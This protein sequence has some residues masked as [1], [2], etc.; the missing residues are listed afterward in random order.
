MPGAEKIQKLMMRFGYKPNLAVYTRMDAVAATMTDEFPQWER[1]ALSLDLRNPEL[2]QRFQILFN[3][4]YFS[5]DEPSN[6]TESVAMANRLMDF[7]LKKFEIGK[8]ERV[9][10]AYFSIVEDK[11]SFRDLVL[12][13]D[14][15]FHVPLATIPAFDDCHLADT[16]Y[17]VSAK[18]RDTKWSRTVQVGPMIK[19][20][21]LAKFPFEIPLYDLEQKPLKAF[22]DAIPETFMFVSSDVSCIQCDR[23]YAAS[24]LPG[25]FSRSRVM[26][27]R[28]H[29]LVKEGDNG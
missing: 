1:S 23:Q 29:A 8:L 21:F 17:I 13:C 28:L 4:C 27:E 11:R 24:N 14:K 7:A 10:V 22:Q 20:E 16:A 25:A 18:E 19:S 3:Y 5:C 15:A 2:H 6:P 26:T 9:G 12:A